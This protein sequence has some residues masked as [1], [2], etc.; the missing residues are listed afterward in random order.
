MDYIKGVA[1]E[2]GAKEASVQRRAERVSP[3]IEAQG[4]TKAQTVIG[5]N[6]PPELQG[7]RVWLGLHSAL[8]PCRCHDRRPSPALEVI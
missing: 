8:Q 5:K 2:K 7:S 3:D 1:L 6:L 4:D